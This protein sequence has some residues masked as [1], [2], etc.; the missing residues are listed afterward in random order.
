MKLNTYGS[1]VKPEPV[2]IMGGTYN[3]DIH[4]TLTGQ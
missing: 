1:F 3:S 2:R 4:V